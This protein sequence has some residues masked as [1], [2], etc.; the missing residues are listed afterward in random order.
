MDFT[1]S[2]TASATETLKGIP[3]RRIQRLI[4]NRAQQLAADPHAL[5]S[6]LRD[7]LRGLFSTRAAGQRYRIIYQI[8]AEQ[9]RVTVV[10]VGIRR[11]GH[12]T[13]IYALAQRLIRLGLVDP[14]RE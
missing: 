10:A 3:D 8:D 12:R 1:V 14:P 6:P 13:D 7:E 4:V 11:E 9:R 5:G 2:F